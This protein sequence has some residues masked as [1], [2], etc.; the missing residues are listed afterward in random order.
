MNINF[1]EM[2]RM[3]QLR[4]AN[5]LQLLRAEGTVNFYEQIA[6]THAHEAYSYGERANMDME[7]IMALACMIA[8]DQAQLLTQQFISLPITS[9]A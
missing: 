1:D 4:T 9:A 3:E 7:A 5:L 2:R 8:G 6:Q